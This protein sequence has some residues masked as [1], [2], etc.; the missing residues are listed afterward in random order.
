MLSSSIKQRI[1]STYAQ[2]NDN[3]VELESRFGKLTQG[4]FKP[5][6]TKEVFNRIR[7]HFEQRAQVIETRTTDYI[8]KNIRKT[9]TV[10]TV[11]S[12]QTIWI[13]KNR[14]WSEDDPNYGI[15]YSMSRE[16]PIHPVD[17]FVPETIREKNRY[18]YSVYKNMVRVDMTVVNMIQ[19]VQGKTK[20]DSTTYEVEIELIDPKGIESFDKTTNIILYRLLDTIVLYNSREA[21]ALVNFVNMTMGSDKRG[22]ID[23]Y[24][25]VQARNL[26]LKDMVWGGLIGNKDTQY[27]VT[28][29]TDGQRKLLVF[30]SS[31]IWLVAPPYSL[32]RISPNE[33]PGLTGTII[34]GELVSLENR[35]EGAPKSRL[36][37][38]AF[39]C[40]A[41]NG[42]A[43]VQAQS[44]GIRMNYSQAVAD[45]MKNELITVNTKSFRVFATPNNFFAV[46]R[47]MFREQEVLAYKQDGFMFTPT[48][49]VYNPHSDN[50]PLYRRVLTD[51]PDICK[52]KPQ[53]QLTIDFQIRWR[54]TPDGPIIQLYVND[55]G[56]PV[57]FRGTQMFPYD[58]DVDDRHVLTSGL[59]NDTIVEYGWDY[60]RNLFTPHK[61][62]YDKTKPNKIDIAED[63][64]SDIQRPLDRETMMGQSLDLMRAYHNK[65]K[66]ELYNEPTKTTGGTKGL[67]LL[68][69]GSGR[70]GDVAK[71]RGY[72]KIVAV[73]PDEE[74]IQELNRR[75]QLNNMSDKVLVVHAGGQDIETIYRAVREFIGDRVDVVSMMLSMSFFWQNQSMVNRLVNTITSNI[76]RNGKIIFLTIDGDLVEQT[77]EPAMD[78]GPA[79]TRLDLGPATLNYVPN[80]T[81]KELHI[82]IE[83]TIVQ[84]QTEWLVRLSDLI[85]PLRT[86]GFDFQYRKRAD[87]ER[88]LN[89]YEITMTQMYTYAII[90]TVNPNIILPEIN[91]VLPGAEI[92]PGLQTNPNEIPQIIPKVIAELVTDE[93]I[94]NIETKNNDYPPQPVPGLPPIEGLND[95]DILPDPMN[96]SEKTD[97]KMEEKEIKKIEIKEKM[98]QFPLTQTVGLPGLPGLPGITGAPSGQT[99]GLPNVPSVPGLPQ[100]QL[101]GLPTGLPTTGALPLPNIPSVPGLPQVQLPGLSTT[102]PTGLPTAALPGLSTTLPTGIPTATSPTGIPT[103]TLPGLPTV[104]GTIPPVTL[105]A[106]PP[107]TGFGLPAVDVE[108]ELPLIPP[109]TYQR[110][111]VTWYPNEQVV[112]IG[113]IGDGSCFFHATL[114]G[115]YPPY[116]NNS[117]AKNRRRFVSM[118]RRDIAYTLQMDDP[119]NPG[120]TLWQ[121]AANGQFE[122]LYEQQLMGLNFDDVFG[123]P[124]D[125]SLEGLQR[126]FNSTSYLGNEVY[127]Y[128]S[129]MLGIDIY[130][131]RLTNRDLYV[132]QNTSTRGVVR[133]VV[134]I[135]GNGNHYETIGVERNG[136]FQTVFDQNDPFIVSLR[137]QIDDEGGAEIPQGFDGFEEIPEGLL[138]E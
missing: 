107:L 135:S 10:P 19:G 85:I 83:G 7:D 136:M 102:L 20:E 112:R 101:P 53:D 12:P 26:K 81:P 128:A 117:D 43:G 45:A 75:I 137:R 99:L 62:R 96:I 104:Q 123:F 32:N 92:S 25:M 15:R 59:P 37:F 77:F 11:G 29:K 72:S 88:L 18:S 113:A 52:W 17:N 51:Y 100:V 133:K 35:L 1:N 132:H 134:V 57:L 31:G 125:F 65:I 118:L 116:Q 127:Q 74:H 8:G 95:V 129:D 110:I 2:Y 79:V 91:H 14:L 55:K 121:T 22:F 64:W 36:W 115:Y 60:T 66:K 40:L 44:H 56:K 46:M 97:E 9:V 109:D 69:I 27:T 61:V 105:P 42:N 138:Y 3:T 126:L 23:H 108:S 87:E 71:W 82:H 78:T 13:T 119:E 38:L 16:I 73:E 98:N 86:M 89:N 111:I 122:A 131:M 67:T 24:M 80:K 68:D 5:G 63:V 124:V 33:I 94:I 6:V 34:D 4:G 58:N 120:M 76:K 49:A 114:N 47:D 54:A 30:H 90:H 93:P 106:L 130:I 39:D 84:D 41:W 28:H 21:N 50:H 103:A 70:G 48:N